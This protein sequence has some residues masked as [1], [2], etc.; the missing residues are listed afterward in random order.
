VAATTVRKVLLRAGSPPAAQRQA[1]TWRHFLRQHAANVWA[2]D[3]FTVDTL[4]LQRIYVLFFIS[5]ERRRIEH[6]AITSNP[7]GAWVTHQAR[8]ITGDLVEH[9]HRPPE[10]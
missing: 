10:S 3:F 4:L 2:C 9:D 6:V 5:L 1:T 7:S 8:T